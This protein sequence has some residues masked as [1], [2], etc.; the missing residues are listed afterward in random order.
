MRYRI[1]RRPIK[2]ARLELRGNEI[3]VIVPANANPNKVIVKNREWI[4]KQLETIKTAEGLAE[5]IEIIPRTRR[6]FKSLV[7]RIIHEY[8]SILGVDVKG[9]SIRKMTTSWGSCSGK[10]TI[11]V[12]RLAQYL[13]EK[14]IRYIVYHEICHLL[15]WRHDGEFEKLI[16]KQF[17]DHRDLDIEL[18]AYLIKLNSL[19]KVARD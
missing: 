2:H 1:I 10:G 5:K 17:P 14:L 12:S 7:E 15:R 8:S 3:W 19:D 9:W 6:K 13:P 11:N 16:S 4:I 18:Q